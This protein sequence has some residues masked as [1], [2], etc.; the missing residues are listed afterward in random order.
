MTENSVI[1]YPI[2][3]PYEICDTDSLNLPDFVDL[4]TFQLV[5]ESAKELPEFNPIQQELT[6]SEI[7]FLEKN[8][9]L[10]LYITMYCESNLTLQQLLQLIWILRETYPKLPILWNKRAESDDPKATTFKLVLQK[11]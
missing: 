6:A 8:T 1:C 7:Q 9:C 4:V 11:S 2:G 3:E 10:L 5:A